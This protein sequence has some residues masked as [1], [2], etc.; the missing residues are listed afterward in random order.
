MG[1]ELR[2]ENSDSIWCCL[3]K[4]QQPKASLN[5][6]SLT[7]SDGGLLVALVLGEPVAC[8]TCQPLIAQEISHEVLR[9]CSA[10][11]TQKDDCQPTSLRKKGVTWE[12]T[13]I[14]K[15]RCDRS[16]MHGAGYRVGA[17]RAFA[18]PGTR[19]VAVPSA[20]CSSNHVHLKNG[21]AQ[22]AFTGGR[23]LQARQRQRPLFPE[24]NPE[25]QR[26]LHGA[27]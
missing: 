6:H 10:T 12:A 4:V 7:Q 1:Y 19:L 26:Q 5:G 15:A 18:G 9:K 25:K 23:M 14:S 20:I 8:R 11:E 21:R 17:L 3:R 22:Q 27:P 2:E 16:N 13:F 24:S